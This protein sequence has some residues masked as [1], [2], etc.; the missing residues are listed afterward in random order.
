MFL[1]LPTAGPSP[2]PNQTGS[3]DDDTS[4]PLTPSPTLETT[5]SLQTAA[6]R[7]LP[8]GWDTAQQNLEGRWLLVTT[9]SYSFTEIILV[10][11]QEMGSGQ[12]AQDEAEWTLSSCR[13]SVPGDGAGLL[14]AP[15]LHWPPHG[16]PLVLLLPQSAG[17]E[18]LCH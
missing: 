1:M 9:C 12:Q 10:P 7:S 3:T 11:V 8:A 2:L 6:Q 18:T 4:E 5:G 17:L 13:V 14:T 15:G 16:P